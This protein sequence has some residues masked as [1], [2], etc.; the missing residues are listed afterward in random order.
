[1][2][3]IIVFL[4]V[5]ISLIVLNEIKINEFDFLN[6]FDSMTIVCESKIDGIDSFVKNGN[7]Y[8]YTFDSNQKNM[9]N[10]IEYEG[11]VFNFTQKFDLDCFIN[12]VDYISQSNDE[13]KGYEIYYGYYGDYK[14]YRYIDGKK[15][16]F[17]LAKHDSTWTLGFP[18]ILTGF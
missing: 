15:I 12:S 18:L 16:N 2:R 9:L 8:Y 10:K 7:Q 1:M 17:Q 5:G 4:F 3:R 14:D 6:D 13:L 11:V